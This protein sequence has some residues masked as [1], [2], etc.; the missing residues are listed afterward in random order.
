MKIRYTPGTPDGL[1]GKTFT[2]EIVE[3]TVVRAKHIDAPLLRLIKIK[4]ENGTTMEISG[5]KLI[6]SINMIQKAVHIIPE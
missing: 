4:Y 3:M 6:D 5:N 1:V 2:V